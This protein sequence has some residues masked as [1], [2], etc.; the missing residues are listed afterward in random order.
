[1]K[2]LTRN[3]FREGCLERDNHKCVVCGE[4]QDLSVHHIIERRLWKDGGYYMDNGATLCERHHIQAETTEL[5]CEEVREYAKIDKVILP[6]DYYGD[7][8]YT[9]WGDVILPNGRRMR[10]PLF[11]DDSVSKILKDYLHLYTDY[12]KYP[13]TW[14]LPWSQ[15]KTKDDKTLANCEHFQGKRVI[16]TEKMDGENCTI[17]KNYIHARSIDGRDHWSRSW[18]KKSPS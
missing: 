8:R 14:H 2:L 7:H 10:G 13:R 17:Y 12:V 4:T 3:E 11:E 16:V 9:K 1:M 18:V 5:S 15:G 6:E